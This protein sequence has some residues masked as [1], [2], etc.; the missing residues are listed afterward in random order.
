ADSRPPKSLDYSK[1]DILFFAFATPNTSSSISYNSGSTSILQR[2]VTAAHNSGKGTIFV[3]S[4]GGWGGSYYFSQAVSS[5]SNCST[6]VNTAVNAVNTYDLDSIDIDWV[7]THL[8][9]SEGTG[10]LYST[11][12]C[13]DLLTFLTSLRSVLGSSKII[14]AAVT[15]EPFLGAN[16]YPL[17]KVA[18]CTAQLS[19]ISIM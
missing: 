10:N 2:L 18:P 12:D 7:G 5:A 8:P 16:G 15:Q 14:S 13:A 3:L 17:T 19:Y 1:F 6:S 9:N 11:A 4:I